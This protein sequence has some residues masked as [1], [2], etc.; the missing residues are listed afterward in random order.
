MEIVG[1]PRGIDWSTALFSLDW[2]ALQAREVK[3]GIPNDK[4]TAPIAQY[5]TDHP[6]ES[7]SDI[8]F[9]IAAN[10]SSILRPNTD[11]RRLG[12]LRPLRKSQPPRPPALGEIHACPK[13]DVDIRRRENRSRGSPRAVR[14]GSAPAL[15]FR[16]PVNREKHYT[17]SRKLDT[18][19][20]PRRQPTLN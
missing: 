4:D 6:K 13:I 12:W 16:E 20:I 9:R 10:R 17:R 18:G 7:A 1:G 3:V 11:R 15:F 8:Y 14:A 5:R 2:D 19:H